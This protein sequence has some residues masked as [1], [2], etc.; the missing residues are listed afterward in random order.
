MV[1]FTSVDMET[2]LDLEGNCYFRSCY[3]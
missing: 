1:E 2:W 3:V